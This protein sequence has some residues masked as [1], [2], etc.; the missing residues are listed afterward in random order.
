MRTLRWL[1]ASM[2]LVVAVATYAI[3]R[4]FTGTIDTPAVLVWVDSGGNIIAPYATM[5]SG[6]GVLYLDSATGL[7]WGL[8][9][10]R[11]TTPSLVASGGTAGQYYATTN[12]TGP[13]YLT[14]PPWDLQGTV[15]TLS[16]GNGLLYAGGSSAAVNIQS[17]WRYGV[18]VADGNPPAPYGIYAATGPLTPPTPPAGPYHLEAR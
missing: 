2:T 15:Y 9:N 16:N 4:T 3:P 11:S 1:F 17:Q 6:S 5:P 13:V 12:C 8:T 10:F 7:V 14:L 18:C